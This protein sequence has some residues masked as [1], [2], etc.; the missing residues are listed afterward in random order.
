MPNQEQ[1]PIPSKTLKEMALIRHGNAIR[2]AL[3]EAKTLREQQA[4]HDLIRRVRKHMKAQQIIARDLL[5][6]EHH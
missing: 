2:Q 3:T 5:N 1:P 4:L 6:K